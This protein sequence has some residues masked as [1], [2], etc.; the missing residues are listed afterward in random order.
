MAFQ[1]STKNTPPF[2]GGRGP[3]PTK[4]KKSAP[5]GLEPGTSEK[6]NRRNPTELYRF[7]PPPTQA[8]LYMRGKGYIRVRA[9]PERPGGGR[10]GAGLITDPYSRWDR[11]CRE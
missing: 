10:P 9:R 11:F 8:L 3:Q 6:C 4:Q 2:W 7:L 1:Q 5:G